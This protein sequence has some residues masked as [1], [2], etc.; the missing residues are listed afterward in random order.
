MSEIKPQE[1][2]ASPH[3]R[4]TALSSKSDLQPWVRAKRQAGCLLYWLPV[5]VFPAPAEQRKWI[6]SFIKNLSKLMAQKFGLRP[7]LFIQQESLN[8]TLRA[9]F[10]N[11]CLELLPRAGLSRRPGA[12]LPPLPSGESPAG[13]EPRRPGSSSTFPCCYW[14]RSRAIEKNLEGYF[15]YGGTTLTFLKPDPN[16]KPPEFHLPKMMTEH[17]L[18]KGIDL[19]AKV[20]EAFVALDGFQ[21]KSKEVFGKGL[22]GHTLFPAIPFIL[23]RLNSSDFFSHNED[24]VAQWFDLFDL[25]LCESPDDR[26]L[27][28]AS[29]LDF[30]GYLVVLLAHMKEDGFNYPER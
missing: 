18:A 15:G 8:P 23:P 20:A 27:L 6:L 17:P 1:P 30:E 11:S 4:L 16:T 19:K 7:E 10:L 26:G 28:L 12:P 13:A 29:R 25:Y 21:L 24:E 2:D 9:K 3:A 14:I 5:S 22:E